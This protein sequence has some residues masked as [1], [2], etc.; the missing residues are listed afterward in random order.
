MA[1]GL[2]VQPSFN[3]SQSVRCH[4]IN[5]FL[6][7]Y[8]EGQVVRLRSG[9]NGMWARQKHLALQCRGEKT[10]TRWPQKKKKEKK[11]KAQ[12]HLNPCRHPSIRDGISLI[13]Y[14]QC[15]VLPV[16]ANRRVSTHALGETCNLFPSVKMKSRYTK[17]IHGYDYSLLR[18]KK[19]PP[20]WAARAIKV[21]SPKF[22]F[23]KESE[24]ENIIFSAADGELLFPHARRVIS[25]DMA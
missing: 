24:N 17:T 3:K 16:S 14:R 22:P 6:V 23:N 1:S 12:V 4:Y 18:C 13:V 20:A 19:P 8:R 25:P 7:N 5:I 15:C 10:K 2:G 21:Y 9:A 11:K